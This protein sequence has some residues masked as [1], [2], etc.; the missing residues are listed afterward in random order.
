MWIAKHYYNKTKQ[1]RT[2]Y[3]TTDLCIIINEECL[4]QASIIPN[5]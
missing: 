3:V 4:K 5:I 1:E 2:T